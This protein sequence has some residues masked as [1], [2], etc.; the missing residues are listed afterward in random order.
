MQSAL[1][2]DP[3]K[4]GLRTLFREWQIQ[5]IRCLWA[6]PMKKFT[7]KQIWDKVCDNLDKRVSRATVYHFLDELAEKEIISFDTGT[8]RGGLRILFYSQYSEDEFKEL[9]ARNLIDSVKDN[10]LSPT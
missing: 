8:G 2:F 5:T 4:K 3:E 7:T 9:M 1:K 10:L 6:K